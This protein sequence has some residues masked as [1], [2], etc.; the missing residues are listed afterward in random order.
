MQYPKQNLDSIFG[1]PIHIYS[2]AQA[3][4]DGSL[5][6]ITEAAC[7]AGF[8]LPVAM[9]AAA[10]ADCVVWN[11]ADSMRQ[12]A[13]NE[14]GRLWDV[15]WMA[16]LAARRAGNSQRIAFTVHRVPRGG[17]SPHSRPTTLH[18]CIGPGDD[19]APVITILLPTED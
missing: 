5:I 18:M 16:S 17:R 6:D 13:Q 12:T 19:G 8:R 1:E 14:A 10:W 4:E 15:L 11:D 2:R 9:T 3:T 7:E